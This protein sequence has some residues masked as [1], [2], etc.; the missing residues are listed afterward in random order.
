MKSLLFIIDTAHPTAQVILADDEKILGTREWENTPHVGTDLLM[1]IEDLLKGMGVDKSGI[2]RVAVHPGP[3]SYGLVRTGIVTATI[4]AQSVG[5]ELVEVQ[6]ESVEELVMS[7]RS[8][9][10]TASL[11]QK[12]NA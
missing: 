7:A 2:S 1:Y 5:A 9:K 11:E 10:P 4:F 12:H 3:G 6:G 8:G